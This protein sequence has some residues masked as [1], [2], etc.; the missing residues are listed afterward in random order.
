MKKII[1]TILITVILATGT[2]SAF[3]NVPM[4][5][6][7]PK[8][9]DT[10]ELGSKRLIE[11]PAPG[12]KV[13]GCKTCKV[14]IMTYDKM[15]PYIDGRIQLLANT[16][17]AIIKNIQY[18]INATAG[19]ITA[20]NVVLFT[21]SARAAISP[22]LHGKAKLIGNIAVGVVIAVEG[23]FLLY[24]DH[25]RRKYEIQALE[26]EN[27]IA[28]T[29]I[30]LRYMKAD[31]EAKNY[32][33]GNYYLISMN[34]QYDKPDSIGTFAK[35]ED[36]VYPDA[37]R[38][39][40]EY[41]KKVKEHIDVVL[42]KLEKGDFSTYKDFNP[43][44]T[45]LDGSLDI[46]KTLAIPITIITEAIELMSETKVIDTQKVIN[47]LQSKVKNLS[48]EDAK[49]IIDVIKYL[50]Q[51]KYKKAIKKVGNIMFFHIAGN[52]QE[53]KNE[54]KSETLAESDTET[55][56]KDESNFIVEEKSKTMEVNTPELFKDNSNSE[57]NNEKFK[58]LQVERIKLDVPN[59]GLPT[60][61]PAA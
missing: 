3:A 15:I 56:S 16:D 55:K 61:T 58:E 57:K 48:V 45:H 47:F 49:Q 30:A 25:Q 13:C 51:G 26:G 31:I 39:D 10:S 12:K 46:L 1:S 50:Y 23:C 11:M 35:K 8:C 41:F 2:G 42:D 6:S 24:Y 33:Y 37:T 53:A 22:F 20:L 54:A 36:L 32:L 60:A 34:N 5:T 7:D 38:Y 4:E 40:D 27:E 19:E 17:K 59:V 9:I 18:K 43:D 21:N 52:K 14:T 28:N 44:K 29:E